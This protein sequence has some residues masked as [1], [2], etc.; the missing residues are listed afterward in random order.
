MNK[1]K[2]NTKSQIYFAYS[3]AVILFVMAAS[4]LFTLFGIPVLLNDSDPILFLPLQEVFYLIAGLE[5][6]LSA[7]LLA[8]RNEK[9]KLR[10][11]VWLIIN[12]FVYQIGLLWSDSPDFLVCLGNLNANFPIPPRILNWIILVLYCYCLLGSCLFLIWNWLNNQK[13]QV[14]IL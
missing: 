7:Y 14:K 8:G 3:V 9:L 12:L 2:M 13:P 6:V 1:K 5:L 4:E 11:I 10:L